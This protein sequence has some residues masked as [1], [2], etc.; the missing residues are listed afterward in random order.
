MTELDTPSATTTDLRSSSARGGA[1]QFPAG[2]GWG[3]ATASYQVEGAAALD[4]RTPSIWDTYAARPGAVVAGDNGDVACDH[5][6]RYR[7]DVALMLP[8]GRYDLRVI[9]VRPGAAEAPAQ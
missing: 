4:G 7:D 6:H 8:P 3:A 2:F 1:I 9:D 5:Y